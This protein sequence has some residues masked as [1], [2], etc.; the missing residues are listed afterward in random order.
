MYFLEMQLFPHALPVVQILQ[1][2][3]VVGA[4]VGA[5]GLVGGCGFGVLVNVGNK[6]TVAVAVGVHVSVGGGKVKVGTN[7]GV[8]DGVNDG[9]RVN[10]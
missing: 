5:G 10:T 4:F 9:V 3:R 2:A 7:E 1:Q 6:V 8:V